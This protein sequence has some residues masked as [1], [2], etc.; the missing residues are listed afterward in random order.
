[1]RHSER[2]LH[3]LITACV[4]TRIERTGA[5]RKANREI[6]RHRLTEDGDERTLIQENMEQS[7]S[8]LALGRAN[9]PTGLDRM[10]E[11]ASVI[12]SCG[13]RRCCTM[14]P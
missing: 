5:S 10:R 6:A 7:D 13:S 1:L 8:C 12:G 4:E 3:V 9:G 14:E 2:G 11:A